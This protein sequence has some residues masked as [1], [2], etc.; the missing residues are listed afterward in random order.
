MSGSILD[1]LRA[2]FDATTLLTG[3]DIGARYHTDMA[4]VAVAPPLAVMRPR[5]TGDVSIFLKFCHQARV[6]LTTQ[7]GMTGLVGATMPLPGEIEEGADLVETLECAQRH[8]LLGR[9]RE[10]PQRGAGDHAE[11]AFGATNSCLR[12]MPVLFLMYLRTPLR[13]VPSAST[14]SSPSTRSRVMP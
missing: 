8:L 6:P 4:G 14:A 2:A 3:A 7:G 1:D 9:R 5:S 11:C 10:D 12:S 13:I